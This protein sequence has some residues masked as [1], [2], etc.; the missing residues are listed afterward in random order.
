L[1]QHIKIKNELN[2]FRNFG[3]VE[4]R[5]F[6]WSELHYRKDTTG[7]VSYSTISLYMTLLSY[8]L[9][10]KAANSTDVPR[11]SRKETVP[12]RMSSIQSLSPGLRIYRPNP[13]DESRNMNSNLDSL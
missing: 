10:Y 4:H 2:I 11:G 6:L 7:Q 13:T 9:A 8:L 12:H 1:S 5:H 3:T